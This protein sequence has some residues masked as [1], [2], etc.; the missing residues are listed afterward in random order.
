MNRALDLVFCAFFH[1][2]CSDP[3]LL[4]HGADAHSSKSMFEA[5]RTG[6]LFTAA[7]PLPTSFKS[8]GTSKSG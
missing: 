7:S 4:S 3:A 5:E 1:D 6:A 8:A 2:V